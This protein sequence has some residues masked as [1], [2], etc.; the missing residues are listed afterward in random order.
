M[1]DNHTSV[2]LEMLH[3]LQMMNCQ[4]N[5]QHYHPPLGM[6]SCHCWLPEHHQENE[7]GCCT[8]SSVIVE[9]DSSTAASILYDSADD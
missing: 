8:K 4:L 2:V 3:F 9:D 5:H 7:D 1:D 6:Y